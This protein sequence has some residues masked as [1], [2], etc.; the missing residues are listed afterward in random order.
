[1]QFRGVKN[2]PGRF[3]VVVPENAELTPH[4]SLAQAL[5][6]SPRAMKRLRKLCSG[7]PASIIPGVVTPA[8][9]KLSTELRLPLLGAGPRNMAL[10]SSK[11]NAKKLCQLA[12][13]PTGPWATD[14]Y[15]EDEFFI[16]LAGLIV[17]HPHVR[18]WLFK[19]D[20]ERDSRGHAYVDLQKMRE[21]VDALRTSVHA[22][23][24]SVSGGV[25]NG[26]DNINGGVGPDSETLSALALRGPED[27]PAAVG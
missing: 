15:D 21:V 14:I 8:E 6:C 27:E 11:S 3:Q 10:L 26:S 20:D 2:P 24:S 7:R 17:K 9:L 25:A 4:L 5:L 22:L 13:L 1:M 12:E 16:S 23:Q 19:I 18:T